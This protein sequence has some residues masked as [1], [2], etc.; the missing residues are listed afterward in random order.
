MLYI[1]DNQKIA[2]LIYGALIKKIRIFFDLL[3]DLKIISPHF[4]FSLT[5][6]LELRIFSWKKH[7]L[8][9]E[10]IEKEDLCKESACMFISDQ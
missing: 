8:L 4:S 3:L 7:C 6:I 10:G 5:L 9:C 1:V 2:F